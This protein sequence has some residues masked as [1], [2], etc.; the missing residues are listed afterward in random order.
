MIGGHVGEPRCTAPADCAC[1]VLEYECD[2][3]WCCQEIVD[4]AEI[5]TAEAGNALYTVEVNPRGEGPLATVRIRYKVP[6]TADYHTAPEIPPPLS[7]F[8][9]ALLRDSIEH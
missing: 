7:F 2:K 6:G 9:L 1:R 8:V 3:L 4:A 5:G